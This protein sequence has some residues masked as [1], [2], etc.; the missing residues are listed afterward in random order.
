M[1]TFVRIF[2]LVVAFG[3]FKFSLLLLLLPLLKMQLLL[4]LL[5]LLLLMLLKL[6][7]LFKLLLRL[8]LMMMELLL[9]LKLLY[10]ICRVSGFE[11][12]ILRPQTGVLPISY[13]LTP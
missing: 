7:L 13:T 5:L 6:L 10:N 8:L 11:P 2:F 3:L 12:K 1:K 4:Y 9:L